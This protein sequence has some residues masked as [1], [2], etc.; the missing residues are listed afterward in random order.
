MADISCMLNNEKSSYILCNAND[1]TFQQPQTV[2]AKPKKVEKKVLPP[3]ETDGRSDLL[4]A[5]REG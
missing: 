2:L 5:I 1:F 3:V 4:K